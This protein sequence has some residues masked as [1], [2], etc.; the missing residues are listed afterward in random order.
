MNPEHECSIGI[1]A[2]GSLINDPGVEMEP[3]IAERIPTQTPFPVEYARL[4]TGRGGG[5]TVVPHASGNP[6]RAEILVLR[7]GVSLAEAKNLLWRRETRN[8]GTGKRY[9][10]GN[11]PNSVLVADAPEFQGVGHVLYTDFPPSGKI[12]RPEAHSLAKAAVASVASAPVGKDGISYLI[13]LSES[14]VQTA[15]TAEYRAEVLR[16]AGAGSLEEALKHLRN[17]RRKE[18]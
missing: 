17:Q 7:P 8:E 15:L 14:G 9:P 13:Q 16:L 4:S 18:P 6:V 12:P 5:P 2:Y 1:L 11:S 10:A 3:L